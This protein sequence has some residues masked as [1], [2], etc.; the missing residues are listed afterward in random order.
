MRHSTVKFGELYAENSRNGIYK[1]KEF[2]GSGVLLVKMNQQFGNRFIDDHIA[3][4]ERIELTDDEISRFELLEND[5]LFSRTSI[6]PE[7]VGMCSIVKAI[8]EPIAFESNIIRI[9]L[10]ES[11]INPLYVFRYFQS[12][13]GRGKVLSIAGGTTIKTIKG[14][15]LKELDIHLP[16]LPKQQKIASILSGYDDL[17][18][19]NQRRIQL[20]EESARLLYKEWF[21][22]FR[23]PG[24]E[25]TKIVDGVPEGWER[26]P[27][28]EVAHLTMG[29]SPKSEFYNAVGD[30]LPFHQGVTNYGE[31]FVSHKIYSTKITR[32]AESGDILCSVSAPVGRLN[33][34]LDKIIL[35]RGLCAISSKFENQSFL[36]YQ[37]KNYFFKED[38]IGSGAIYAAVTKKDMETLELLKPPVNIVRSF[39]GISRPFDKQIKN[40]SEQN[41]KL[42]QARDM[43]LPRLMNGEIEV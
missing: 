23:F 29:Q 20:L 10:D 2:L 21:V 25:N 41:Q 33:Y 8:D 11:K 9:R 15:S 16:P 17:I 35:G 26:K 32:L 22:N 3:D 39:E 18:E 14:S 43:L 40:L 1:S 31:R 30:G 36:F 34:T 19:N 27:L 6:V 38:I 12:Y 7:G 42:A 13:I 5:L 4:F 24:H 28:V 37:L